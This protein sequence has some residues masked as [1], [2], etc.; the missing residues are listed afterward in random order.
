MEGPPTFVAGNCVPGGSVVGDEADSSLLAALARRNDK[1]F[2]CKGIGVRCL[3][4][5]ALE[6]QQIPPCSLRSL[7]GMTRILV[8]GRWSALFGVRGVGM[9]ADSSLLAALARRNDKDFWFLC[10]GVTG[11]RAIV[12]AE[13]ESKSPSCR[14][15]R[16]KG[17][18][19]SSLD[20]NY[21]ELSYATGLNLFAAGI[22]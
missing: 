1:D 2:G 14:K 5:G 11:R 3:E 12:T 13:R 6:W 4:C 22:V 9:A 7:V 8:Q 19:P 15:V 10:A 16:D 20:S 18:A 21:L 17:G